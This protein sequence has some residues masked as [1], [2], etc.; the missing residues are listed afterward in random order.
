MVCESRSNVQRVSPGSIPFALVL[1]LMTLGAL[2]G[3]AACG[4]SSNNP[5]PPAAPTPPIATPPPA[6]APPPPP[7]QTAQITI[8][9]SGVAPK[10]VTVARGGRVTFVN[11]DGRAHDVFS[12]PDHLGTDCPAINVVGFL[13]AGRRGETGSLDIVRRCGYH[14][15]LNISDDSMRGVIIVV[16][17]SAS[18]EPAPR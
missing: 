9:A 12:D 6:P 1:A 5:A 2:T 3:M 15:H 13:T 7:P 8:T 11:D 14:D 16:E 17:P 4:G 10:E 18:V